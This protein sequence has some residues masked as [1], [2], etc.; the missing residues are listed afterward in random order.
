MNQVI[1]RL[2]PAKRDEAL[3]GGAATTMS[4]GGSGHSGHGGGLGGG[5]GHSGHD[6]GLGDQLARL[7]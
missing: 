5:S 2:P 7:V 4:R 6:G 1:N 3:S